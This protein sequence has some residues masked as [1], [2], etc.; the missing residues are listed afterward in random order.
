[1]L[2]SSTMLSKSY[3][4]SRAMCFYNP[5][6]NTKEVRNHL[7]DLVVE[8]NHFDD[9]TFAEKYDFAKLLIKIAGDEFLHESDSSL[10]ISNMFNNDDDNLVHEIKNLAVNYYE[11]VMEGLF[12]QA[13]DNYQQE[14]NEWLDHA[15][16]NGDPDEAY[17]RFR[18][19]FVNF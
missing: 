1:M 2:N 3:H 6:F 11:P 4:G 7:V 5:I 12:N 14:R 15:A 13:K 10:L 8:N 9:L 18:D 17:D 16:K 19:E